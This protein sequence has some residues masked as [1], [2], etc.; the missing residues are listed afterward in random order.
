VSIG[1]LLV[2]I[3]LGAGALFYSVD[4]PSDKLPAMI[5][6]LLIGAAAFCSLG[7]AITAFIPNADA[8]PAIVNASILPLLF[9]SNIFYSSAS[10]PGWLNAIADVF[11]VKHFADALLA[12]FNPH[13]AGSGFM[14][15]DLLILAVWGIAGVLVSMRFFTWEPRR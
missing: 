3:V 14:G 10:A 13:R 6:A 9:I 7:L 15:W 2:V 1:V 4:L 11:P 12:T 5:I 8:A